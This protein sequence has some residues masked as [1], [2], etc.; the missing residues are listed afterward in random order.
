MGDASNWGGPQQAPYPPPAPKRSVVPTIATGAVCFL[1]GTLVGGAATNAASDRH[2]GTTAAP[3]VAV[4]SATPAPNPVPPPPAEAS[5]A[6]ASPPPVEAS[7]EPEPPPPEEPALPPGAVQAGRYKFTDLQIT[8]DFV[9]DFDMR[10]RVTNTGDSIGGVRWTATLF[11]ED[12]I[13][14]VLVAR[15]SDFGTGQTR[16]VDWLSTDDFVEGRYLV[17]IQVDDE[18]EF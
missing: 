1:V 3:I 15:V 18:Y 9:G 2:T 12:R 10:S 17:E 16:T 14:A 6:P 7:A 5:P 13:V 4:G 11:L 8:E